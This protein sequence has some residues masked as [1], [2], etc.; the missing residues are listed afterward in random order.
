MLNFQVHQGLCQR[1]L[2]TNGKLMLI[3]WWSAEQQNGSI[4]LIQKLAAHFRGLA[5][6][7]WHLTGQR[8]SL[9]RRCKGNFHLAAGYF[10][11]IWNWSSGCVEGRC[12]WL[13]L[14]GA[15]ESSTDAKWRCVNSRLQHARGHSPP[16][17]K[18]ISSFQGSLWHMTTNDPSW[19]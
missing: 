13:Q 19:I 3:R 10:P 4:E 12:F 1:S 16:W 11:D 5:D 18:G 9:A 8:R 7:S 17:R 6:Q 14:L 15:F 2:A